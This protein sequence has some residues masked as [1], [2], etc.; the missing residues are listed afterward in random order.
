MTENNLEPLTGDDLYKA[1]SE[2]QSIVPTDVDGVS[3][4]ELA[5]GYATWVKTQK[6]AELDNHE[7]EVN[8]F[9]KR[10]VKTAKAQ[11]Q[12]SRFFGSDSTNN[13]DSSFF[14]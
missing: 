1:L 4:Y 13:N 3:A 9:T 6:Q 5:T 14:K 11:Q 10:I 7:Q 8:N 2:G 12:P